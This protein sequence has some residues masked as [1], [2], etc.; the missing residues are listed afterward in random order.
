LSFSRKVLGMSSG[1]I[2]DF[3]LKQTLSGGELAPT[4]RSTEQEIL[5]FVK[6]EPGAISYV[7]AGTRLPVEVKAVTVTP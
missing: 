5:E 3:W 2:R 6:A 1:E 7:S 4:V